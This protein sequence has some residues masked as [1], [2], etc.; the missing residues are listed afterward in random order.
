MTN[1]ATALGTDDG[2]DVINTDQVLTNL[3]QV[4]NVDLTIKGNT[5]VKGDIHTYDEHGEIITAQ[6]T[7]GKGGVFG[8]GDASAVNGN[9]IVKIEATSTEGDKVGIMNVY[10]GGNIA[11]VGGNTTVTLQGNSI[12]RGNVFGGGNEGAVSGS[13]EVNIQE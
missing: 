8:G 11:E 4:N 9:A 7:T 12:V 2:V 5:Y 6:T 3:G 13:T 1:N 10:G